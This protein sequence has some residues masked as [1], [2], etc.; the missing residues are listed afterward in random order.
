MMR[1]SLRAS[2][3][4]RFLIV[5]F[6]NEIRLVQQKGR[7]ERGREWALFNEQTMKL[8]ERPNKGQHI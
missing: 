2:N 1:R 4:R 7:E 8:I 3:A 5:Y 6:V